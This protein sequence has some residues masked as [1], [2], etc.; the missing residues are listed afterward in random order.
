MLVE[1]PNHQHSQETLVVYFYNRLLPDEADHI[2]ASAN[3]SLTKLDTESTWELIKEVADKRQNCKTSTHVLKGKEVSDSD[4]IREKMASYMDWLATIVKEMNT[5]LASAQSK[6][7][8]RVQA[9]CSICYPMT[10]ISRD[11]P[12]QVEEISIMY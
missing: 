6:L 8:A 5:R 1:C 7:V 12:H 3:G 4:P 9:L 10:H 2:D 11:C